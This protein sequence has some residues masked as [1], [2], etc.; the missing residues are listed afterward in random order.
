M[1]CQ[2]QSLH[3]K[4][5]N[6]KRTK[7]IKMEEKQEKNKEIRKFKRHLGDV[8]VSMLATG[9]EGCRFKTRPRRWIFKG[10]K[11]PQH[12]FLSDGK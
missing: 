8:V 4:H 2:P 11:N 12:T 9:P 1:H 5:E 3:S 10:D 7:N 6:K